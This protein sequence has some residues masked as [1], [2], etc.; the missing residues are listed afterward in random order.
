MEKF[1]LVAKIVSS[2]EKVFPER[3]PANEERF[4]TMFKNERLNFQIAIYN[5]EEFTI[6][7]N[8]IVATGELK[9]CV[10][11]REVKLMPA[12][13]LGG[14]GIDD[15]YLK[16]EPG[17][18][19][20]L[21]K[22][23]GVFGVCVPTGQWRA[24]WVSVDLK[25]DVKAG[26]YTI[27]F[28]IIDEFDNLS[29]QLSYEVEVLDALLEPHGM[30]MTNWM[31]YDCISNYHN[32]PVFSDEYYE[33]F[34]KYL[35]AYVDCGFN[36]LLVPLFTPPLDTAVGL[37]RNTAQ[38]VKVFVKNGEY[39]FDFSALEKFLD[40][41]LARGIEYIEFSHLFTQWGGAHCPKIVADVDGKEE[42]IFGW[43]D[44]SL[45]EPYKKFLTAVLPE[46]VKIVKARGLEKKVVFHL[47][48]EPH[49]EHLE[50]YKGCYELVKSL[51]G[52]IPTMDALSDYEFYETGAVDIPVPATNAAGRFIDEKMKDLHV[53]YCCGPT[54][55]YFSNRLFNMPSQR[56]RIIGMQLYAIDCKGFLHWGFNFYNTQCSYGEIDPYVDT[57]AGGVFPAGDSFIVYPDR[58]NKGV[59]KSLRAETLKE[60]W[61]DHRALK[62]LEKY[63]GKEYVLN[64]LKEEGVFGLM[65]YPRSAYWHT[66]FRQK[67]NAL[68]KEKL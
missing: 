25:D 36:M 34:E 26:K 4:S 62:T 45:G 13:K 23:F 53:Y 10:S 30:R 43:A 63:Y 11:I 24:Y 8:K 19:P 55:A 18:Y 20:D 39:S 46:I 2:M 66:R 68:I 42:K 28:D 58:E 65:D 3:E 67:V 51:I 41:V 57:C 52:D 31:H 33:I 60:A 1:K 35:A 59:L 32:V 40:F 49:K 12:E 21:L 27:G 47:T 37:E 64:L 14:K 5:L 16:Y 44:D 17:L 29:A 6:K 22:P 61:Q 50:Q 7:R 9:D 48:D 56:T 38:L 15:Y 54:H